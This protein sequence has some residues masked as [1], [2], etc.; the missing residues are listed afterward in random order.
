MRFIHATSEETGKMNACLSI[1]RCNGGAGVT[2]VNSLNNRRVPPTSCVA[3]AGRSA[4]SRLT[5]SRQNSL[6]RAESTTVVGA[7]LALRRV[8]S[9]VVGGG[10]GGSRSPAGSPGSAVGKP[11][12]GLSGVVASSAK[13]DSETSSSPH[14]DDDDDDQVRRADVDFPAQNLK[15]IYFYTGAFMRPML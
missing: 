3:G 6:R 2:G 9:L 14:E 7:R 15:V 13:T 11:P 10:G 1:S 12:P 8:S 4:A 5:L